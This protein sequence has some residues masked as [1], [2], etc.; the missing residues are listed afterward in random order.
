MEIWHVVELAME[1]VVIDLLLECPPHP[2]NIRE[3]LPVAV[4]SVW[5]A[6]RACN[7]AQEGLN[8]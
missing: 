8:P 6:A 5:R 7:L 2:L 1:C 4:G 3:A